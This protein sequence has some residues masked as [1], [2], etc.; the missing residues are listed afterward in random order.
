MRYKGKKGK[1]W[2]EIKRII[3]TRYKHCYTCGAKNLEGM[4][5][6]AG[7]YRPVAIVGSNNKKAWDLNF[8]RL[9]CGRCNGVGQG[10]TLEFNKRLVQELGK[11]AV[12]AYDKAVTAKTVDP[13]DFDLLLEELQGVHN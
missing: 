6:H 9:Q 12:E 11:E 3:R 4:N 2:N 5:A 1:C 13:V 10:M 8:I 7:H